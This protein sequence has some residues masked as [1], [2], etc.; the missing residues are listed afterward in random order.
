M[1]Q[2]VKERL[3]IT[4]AR[5]SSPQ[6]K[7]DG[8]KQSERW[9]EGGLKTPG[10]DAKEL[11]ALKGVDPQKPVLVELLWKRTTVSQGWLAGD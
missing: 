7:S 2:P 4:Q 5:R 11:R 3:G 1:D 6:V 10:L 8:A 9:L